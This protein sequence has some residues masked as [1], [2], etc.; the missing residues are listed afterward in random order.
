[1]NPICTGSAAL[2]RC[3]PPRPNTPLKPLRSDD[4]SSLSDFSSC[5]IRGLKAR[6]TRTSGYNNPGSALV[7]CG[8]SLR[9]LLYG[10]PY[11]QNSQQDPATTCI[12][13]GIRL[14]ASGWN[15]TR[16]GYARGC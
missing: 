3:V 2:R 16:G 9:P 4:L 8:M 1:M 5:P 15:L 10:A 14:A 12:K 11:Q 13:P 7:N 6:T